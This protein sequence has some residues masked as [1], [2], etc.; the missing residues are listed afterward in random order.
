MLKIES[1][2][3]D[4]INEKDIV[5]ELSSKQAHYIS[6]AVPGLTFSAF[7]CE[8]V[9]KLNADAYKQLFMTVNQKN[10]TGTKMRAKF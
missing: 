4:R 2:R 6:W 10:E 7:Y 8:S 1:V 3:S 5:N 9:A